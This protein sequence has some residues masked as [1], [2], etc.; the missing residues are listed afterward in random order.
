MGLNDTAWENLFEKYRILDE[1]RQKGY[2]LISAGQ[3]REFREPRLM[4]KFDHK[5]NL[6]AAFSQNG[7]SILPVT[8]GDYVISSFSAYKEFEPPSGQVQRISVPLYLQSLSPQFLVSEAIALNCAYACGILQDFLEDDFILPTVSGRMGSGQ[9]DF[10][11]DKWLRG[12]VE[13]VREIVIS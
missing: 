5:V 3:I 8:R 11:V 7:L 6:P 1:I 2:F 4:T 10:F 13:W 12:R 9:F